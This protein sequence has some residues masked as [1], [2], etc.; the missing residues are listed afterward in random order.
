MIV[1]FKFPFL[2]NLPSA[3]GNPVRQRLNTMGS[4]AAQYV[5]IKRNDCSQYG[6]IENAIYISTGLR[7]SVTGVTSDSIF[8]VEGIYGDSFI[9]YWTY[10]R[11]SRIGNKDNDDEGYGWDTFENPPE[12]LDNPTDFSPRT[13]K[14][15]VHSIVESDIN[16]DLR[17]EGGL[18]KESYYPKLKNKTFNLDSAVPNSAK[19]LNSYLNG[20]Y[21]NT[22]A[23]EVQDFTD[24]YYAYNYDYSNV[25]DKMLYLPVNATYK[26]CDCIG[27]LP[28]TIAYSNKTNLNNFNLNDF[29]AENYLTVPSN[30][31]PI[32]NLFVLNNS[33]YAH[34]R[35]IIWKIFSNEKQLKLD[36]N[37]VYIGQGDLFGK[38]PLSV[39]ASDVGYA[40]NILQFGTLSTENGYYFYD[41]YGGKIHHFTDKLDDLGLKKMTN[42]FKDNS[43]FCLPLDNVD[44]YNNPNGIGVKFIYDYYNNRLLLSKKDYDINPPYVYGGIYNEDTALP[45]TIYQHPLLGN[46]LI[47]LEDPLEYSFISLHDNTYFCDKSFTLSYSYN[48]DAWVSFHSFVPDYYLFNRNNFYSVLDKKFIDIM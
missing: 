20:F 34:T 42:F 44:N 4:S 21:Y 23:E 36:E 48:L 1:F 18:L 37:T 22:C 27:E 13:L 38:D 5:S 28:N 3:V 47:T 19:P 30:Y 2:P 40:G 46:F 31:G 35:D 39:Y 11:T 43:K 24:N 33:L 45:N 15:L 26:T 17:H 29:L 10:R 8:S 25:N 41:I 14:T 16:V 32:N 12:L 7:M 6:R 9:N